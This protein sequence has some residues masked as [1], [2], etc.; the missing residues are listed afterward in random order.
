MENNLTFEIERL[1][2][3]VWDLAKNIVANLEQ[4]LSNLDLDALAEI[5][6]KLEDLD[7]LV[8]AV[9]TNTANI[10]SLQT[11]KV[12]KVTG[13][14][15]SS[16]DYTNEEKQKL[17]GIESGANN[18]VLPN[19][20]ALKSEIPS[21]LSDLQDDATHRVVTDT[22]KQ[23][24]NNKQAKLTFDTTPKPNSYNPVV[25]YG[26][27]NALD[28][29]ANASDIPT[30]TSDLNNDSNF[31]SDAN[32]VHTDNNFTTTEKTKL[33]AIESGAKVNV[34]SNW[35][36]SDSTS[37]AFIQNK[38]TI[39]NVNDATLT[40]QKEGTTVATFSANALTNASANIVETDPVFGVTVIFILSS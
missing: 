23:T 39:P 18:Y 6:S 10:S 15:L 35:N 16:N 36:E 37:D 17:A 34:Q 12:D 2:K 1:K 32:Y 22:E 38:P 24:W 26:I 33:S 21:N 4:I 5:S 19:T 28:L 9:E 30:K 8:S 3:E 27:K 11:E 13:K 25:S 20:V 14:G 29:K 31:I 40:I 7:D